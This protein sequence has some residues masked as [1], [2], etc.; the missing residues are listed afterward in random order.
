VDHTTFCEKEIYLFICKTKPFASAF[1]IITKISHFSQIDIPYLLKFS[2]L[3][4]QRLLKLSYYFFQIHPKYLLIFNSLKSWEYTPIFY[5]F[6]VLTVLYLGSTFV[7]AV[8]GIE[9]RALPLLSN[10]SDT[11]TIPPV[12]LIL[13]C[14]FK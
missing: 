6:K 14:F 7:L 13:V 10:Y 3:N 2:S 12:L 4:L 8:L 11:R 9:L 1:S 5:L